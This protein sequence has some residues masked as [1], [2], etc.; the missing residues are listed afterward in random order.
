MTTTTPTARPRTPVPPIKRWF[1]IL[2]QKTLLLQ[3][4][5][6][7]GDD[8]LRHLFVST[9]Q[10]LQLGYSLISER[11]TRTRQPA[12]VNDENFFEALKHFNDRHAS[13]RSSSPPQNLTYDSP[14]NPQDEEL[15]KVWWESEDRFASFTNMAKKIISTAYDLT[16]NMP[17]WRNRE[18]S[19]LGKYLNTALILCK[20]KQRPRNPKNWET[21]PQADLTF[22]HSIQRALKSS[23]DN[24]RPEQ[25]TNLSFLLADLE[26]HLGLHPCYPKPW[27][28]EQPKTTKKK[29]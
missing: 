29:S 14:K 18:E 23:P 25:R 7:L 28:Q 5:E 24:L 4:H 8:L 22:A 11:R 19:P 21:S 2:F 20:V 3:E 1:D 17:T 15:I 6:R 27:P 26:K 13:E 16:K 9:I 10:H 12:N